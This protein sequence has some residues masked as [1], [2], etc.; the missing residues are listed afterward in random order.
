MLAPIGAYVLYWIPMDNPVEMPALISD[1]INEEPKKK[2]LIVIVDDDFD[3]LEWC[4]LVLEPA[5][6]STARFQQADKALEFVHSERPALVITD[7][8]MADLDSGFNFARAI[9]EDPELNQ[10][11]V[12]IITAASSRYGFDFTPRSETDLSAMHV[13][14]FFSKPADA[15]TLIASIRALIARRRCLPEG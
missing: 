5:G 2:D 6:F 3:V 4:R 11:P 15:N 9:K 1:A 8:M 14:A 12:I 7:L 10:I 13:D